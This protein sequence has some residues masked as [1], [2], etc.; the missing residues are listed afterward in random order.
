M[1][2]KILTATLLVFG[3]AVLSACGNSDNEIQTFAGFIQIEDNTLHITPVEI[4]TTFEPTNRLVRSLVRVF[5]WDDVQGMSEFGLVREN[6]LPSGIHIHPN[7]FEVEDYSIDTLTFLIT[8]NTEFT[9]VDNLLLFDTYPDG[10]RQRTTNQLDEFLNTTS[11]P[12][13]TL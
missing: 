2:N 7:W 11:H 4:F 6:H 9:F 12:W 13:Y 8:N 3:L 10:N 1:L 5:D